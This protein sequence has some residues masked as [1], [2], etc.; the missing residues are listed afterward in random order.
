MMIPS[1]RSQY[2]QARI[3]RRRLLRG[4]ALAGLGAGL[5]G[6]AGCASTP[7]A[8]LPSTAAPPAAAPP[9]AATPVPATPSPKLGGTFR[10]SSP[11]ETAHM[12]PHLVGTTALASTGPGIAY[13]K[14]VQFRNDVKPGETI[15]TADLAESWEQPDDLTYIFKIR[16]G[17]KW[18][19][20]PPVNGREVTAAD[21]KYSYERQIDLKIQAGRLPAFS[22][23]EVVDPYTLKMTIP[24][25][26]ADF[27]ETLASQYNKIVARE[28][29]EAKGDLK[30]AP[31]IGS[32]PWILEKWESQKTATFNKNPDY[33]F[34]GF[35]RVDRIEIPRLTDPAT[36]I[37]AFRGKEI[38]AITGSSLT[39]LDGDTLRKGDPNVVLESYKT[40]QGVSMFMNAAKPPFTDKRVRQAFFKAI[41]KQLIIDTVF[42][43]QGWLYAA[44]KMPT[45]DM[46]LPDAEI[47]QLYKRDLAAAKQLLAEAKPELRELEIFVLGPNFQVFTNSAELVQANLRELG[48]QTRIR[49]SD[50]S[51]P[52]TGA[53]YTPGSGYDMLVGSLAATTT[54]A[55]AIRLFH[56]TGVN[57]GGRVVDPAVDAMIDKQAALGKDPEARKKILLDLQRWIIDQAQMFQLL[58]QIAP[59]V[60]YKY[61]QDY[62]Y[63][64][65]TEETFTRLWLDK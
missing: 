29:V 61:V 17:A 44:V 21:I 38:D 52:W 23:I 30:E 47:Q 27:V 20:I 25:P 9:A 33:Y 37:S 60:R 18:H 54:T 10:I 12:D 39:Y 62:F 45:A 11:T 22:K 24:K 28:A 40:V 51:P 5:A 59:S 32:G 55:D 31:L 63:A 49:I 19:N 35:P 42:N 50:A 13:S 7:P 36:V 6:V 57:N 43:G 26:N 48:V 34:K 3:P 1:D 2:W 41:D 56:S 14:L 4:A 65:I 15:P 8:A 53:A 16:R 58:G 64:Y 46:Y